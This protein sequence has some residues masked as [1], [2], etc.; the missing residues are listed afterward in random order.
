M[1]SIA[2]LFK[3]LSRTNI[4]LIHSENIIEKND[5]PIDN[6]SEGDF[7]IIIEDRYYPDDEY[8]MQFKEKAIKSHDEKMN[9][10]LKD[11]TKIFVKPGMIQKDVSIFEIDNLGKF[12]TRFLIVSPNMLFSELLESIYLIYGSDPKDLR[13]IGPNGYIINLDE[14][15]KGKKVREIMS[16][17]QYLSIYN[18]SIPEF[19]CELLGKILTAKAGKN[20]QIKVGR[21]NS[22]KLLFCIDHGFCRF[23]EKINSII[24]NNKEIKKDDENI[25]YSLGINH[26]FDCI[27]K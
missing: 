2:K 9:V 25:F 10:V 21:L 13:V 16:N 17:G 12:W 24:I 11:E 19:G 23:N 26:N 14:R 1:Y 18:S 20:M 5:S 27:L 7:I 4:L 6:I 22:T 15:K 3:D 8:F